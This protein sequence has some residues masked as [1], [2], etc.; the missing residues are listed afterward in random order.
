MAALEYNPASAAC[1]DSQTLVAIHESRQD[2]PHI[3][4]QAVTLAFE[5]QQWP[6]LVKQISSADNVIVNKALVVALRYL[7]Q[8]LEVSK[9]V[10]AGVF[11]ALAQQAINSD[12]TI[13][14]HVSN[15]LRLLLSDRAVGHSAAASHAV[16]LQAV[17]GLSCD[18][19]D[20]TRAAAYQAMHCLSMSFDG[21]SHLASS[22]FVPHLVERIT[23]ET[24]DEM[25]AQLTAALARCVNAHGQKG[26]AAA[27]D[28]DCV[29][30]C[31]KLLQS[32]LEQASPSAAVLAGAASTLMY[33][34]VP[35]AGK[36]QLIEQG[37]IAVL[38]AVLTHAGVSE[39]GT[40]AAACGALMNV[41][42]D[43]AGKRETLS[44]G[45]QP[46]LDCLKAAAGVYEATGSQVGVVLNAMGALSVLTAHPDGRALSKQGGLLQLNDTCIIPA[47]EKRQHSTLLRLASKARGTVDWHP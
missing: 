21:A 24:H 26:V 11:D 20:A 18:K 4:P 33:A 3:H 44:I 14:E 8:P 5:A 43:D 15:C 40:V 30:V 17:K 46:L 22:G 2:P 9:A 13:R 38:L 12:A 16:G 47:A 1:A 39:A 36:A 32:Q 34:A 37:S 42:V 31:T 29:L 6:E 41:A 7:P 35:A 23:S 25:H 19:N 27:L 45:A 28:G 10:K